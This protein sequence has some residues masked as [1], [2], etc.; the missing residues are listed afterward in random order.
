V[1]LLRRR[2]YVDH[3]GIVASQ[4]CVA[5]VGLKQD[6]FLEGGPM[7]IIQGLWPVKSCVALI[8]RKQDT[9]LEGGPMLII[10]GLWPVRVA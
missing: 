4:S 3:T 7:L 2:N 5:L 6:T 9:F 8:G 1:Y 10:Q